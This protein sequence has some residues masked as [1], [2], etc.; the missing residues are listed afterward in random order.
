MFVKQDLAMNTTTSVDFGHIAPYQP[1][2]FVAGQADLAVLEQVRPLFQALLDRNVDSSG[3]LQNWIME[4]CELE[5]ELSQTGTILYI[6]M[7]CQTDD[8]ARARAYQ[9]FIETIRP[10]VKIF[11][12]QLNKKFLAEQVK[13]KLDEKRYAVYARAIRANIEL[14]AEENVPL[15]TEVDLLTQE[16]QT[17]TGAMTVVFEGKERT[18]PEIGKFLYEPDR[19]LRERAWK[20]AARRRLEDKNALEQLFDRLISLRVKI[21]ENAQCANFCDYK[22]RALHRFDYTPQDCKQYHASMEKLLVPLWRQILEKRREHMKLKKLRP[23]DIAVDSLGRPP[24]RPFNKVSEL[25]AGCV[26]I[27]SRLDSELG[28]QFIEMVNAGLLDLESRKGKAPGGYQS[29]L[30]EARKP[31]IFMNAVGVDDDLRTLLHEAGHAFHALACAA[32]PLLDYRHGPME[33]NEVASMG[34]ELLADPQIS[35][36]YGPQDEQRSRSE[37][38]EGIISTLIW[39]AVI[40]AFQYWIYEHPKH[41]SGQRKDAWL[42]IHERFGGNL[43]N[44]EGLDDEHAF[45]WHRQLH[46]F[47]VPFYYIEYGIAQLGALQLWDN[48]RKDLKTALTNYKKALAFG[49]S[50]PLP[51]LFETAGIKFDFSPKTIAPIVATIKD[52]IGLH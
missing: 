15:E 27:F 8:P 49:G 29:T 51:E 42:A 10:V 30:D 37:H 7:T 25:V 3:T 44:W 38:W 36:F 16:Y 2:R 46:I 52:Q 32:D 41:N 5:S 23:W 4:R 47:E 48:A 20:S 11:E 13:W 9:H 31:F 24:L 40:D 22:F 35:I 34:M 45:L 6:R 26:K 14:F 39:V 43:I 12:D 21:A 50:R 28:R 18:L 33:F 19:D 1:R 17:I